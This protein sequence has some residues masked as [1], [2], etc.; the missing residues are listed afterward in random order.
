MRGR[1]AASLAVEAIET[2]VLLSTTTAHLTPHAKSTQAH[3]ADIAA[4]NLHATVSGTY[5]TLAHDPAYT[6]PRAIRAVTNLP[7]LGK[8]TISGTI[9]G[10]DAKLN[11]VSQRGKIVISQ[12]A[13]AYS[14]DPTITYALGFRATQTSGAYQ[15]VTV[16]GFLNF[17][18]KR[19][20]S[21]SGKF[22]LKI[23][24]HAFNAN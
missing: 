4:L 6:A 5:V 20:D 9:N 14:I 1:R 8:T 11:I 17:T 15:N 22:T 10:P 23:D 2:R 13:R 18:L 24:S 12:F 7:G 16:S 3:T 21:P 19:P